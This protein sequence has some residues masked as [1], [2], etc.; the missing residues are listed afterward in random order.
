M[1]GGGF[2]G[3]RACSWGMLAH[4]SNHQRTAT[5]GARTPMRPNPTTA[6]DD[7][8]PQNAGYEC[9]DTKSSSCENSPSMSTNAVDAI[10][11]PAR[12]AASCDIRV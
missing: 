2:A 7:C 6:A 11:T 8:A 3:A 10:R 12:R 1:V 4:L 5:V 9:P